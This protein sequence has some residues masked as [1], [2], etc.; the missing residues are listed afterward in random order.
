MSWKFYCPQCEKI[1]NR[2]QV[3]KGTDNI[4]FYW[5]RC[6]Y[7]GTQVITLKEAV[8]KTIAMLYKGEKENG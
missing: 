5:H 1:K 6:K 3:S 4:R 2:F 7:C 8:E